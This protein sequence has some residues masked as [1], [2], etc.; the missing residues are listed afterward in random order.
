MSGNTDYTS[1]Y[2]LYH[3]IKIQ[4]FDNKHNKRLFFVIYF[5]FH[6]S[7]LIWSWYMLQQRIYWINISEMQQMVGNIHQ[8]KRRRN[9]FF[10]GRRRN[11]GH[12]IHRKMLFLI[13]FHLKK[14]L[15]ETIAQILR[16]PTDIHA[17]TGRYILIIIV[18]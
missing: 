12:V 13:P 1:P 5:I 10:C 14:I 15:S 11:A 9:V 6:N 2:G 17:Y 16:L 18:I 3:N 4:L 7:I 8:S